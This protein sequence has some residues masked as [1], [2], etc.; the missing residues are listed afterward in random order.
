VFWVGVGLTAVVGG[1]S[2]WSGLDTQ[3]NPGTN[4]VRD[5]CQ[6]GSP[7]CQSLYQK[8]VDKQHRTNILIGATAGLGVATA[9]IGAFFTDWSGGKKAAPDTE[10]AKARPSRLSRSGFS[11]EPWFAFGSGASVGALGRF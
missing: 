5:A 4:K 11:V 2:V 1:V 8:G 9:V 7:D 10:A 3:N 6:S